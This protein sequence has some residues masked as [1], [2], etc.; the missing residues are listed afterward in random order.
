MHPNAS[1][2]NDLRY[3]DK[4]F[5]CLSK[6]YNAQIN[7]LDTNLKIDDVIDMGYYPLSPKGT[8]GLELI[9]RNL[10]SILLASNRWTYNFPEL[11][12]YKRDNYKKL[13]KQAL[14]KNDIN[15]SLEIFRPSKLKVSLANS[16]KHFDKDDFFHSIGIKIK[17]LPYV[18]FGSNN[19]IA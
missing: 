19:R 15:S 8:V 3:W 14:I 10:P 12:I 18:P 4:L 6:K 5:K 9:E 17:N 2:Y 1:D 13:I 11:T 7:F 16:I